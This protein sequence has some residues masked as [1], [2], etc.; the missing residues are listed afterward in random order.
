MIVGLCTIELHLPNGYSLKAKRQILSS[1][2]DRLRGKFNVSIAEVGDQELWQKA[3]LG[4]AC[5]TNETGYANRIMDQVINL[6]RST[7]SVEV[8]QFRIEML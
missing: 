1:L 8:L 3:I 7:P 6:I 2:K 5:V 4:V